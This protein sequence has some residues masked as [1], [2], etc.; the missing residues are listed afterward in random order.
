MTSHY[1]LPLVPRDN[2]TRAP[3]LLRLAIEQ[4]QSQL[5]SAR[6]AAATEAKQTAAATGATGAGAG[7]SAE[8]VSVL[9]GLQARLE[10][11]RV[12]L[13]LNDELDRGAAPAA[14]KLI[15]QGTYLYGSLLIQP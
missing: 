10:L 13:S 11:R 14:K 15:T 7:T 5:K 4:V 2:D 9:E 12:L 3:Q 6:A 1:D 8:T